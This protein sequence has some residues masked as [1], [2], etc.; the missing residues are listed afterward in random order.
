MCSHIISIT[1]TKTARTEFNLVTYNF[2]MLIHKN[3]YSML[4]LSTSIYG[5][6]FFFFFEIL[7]KKLDKSLEVRGVVSHQRQT[8][9]FLG[10]SVCRQLQIKEI[11]FQ[12][13]RIGK[14]D[15]S[16]TSADFTS[17]I[18]VLTTCDP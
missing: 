4:I 14:I 17:Q 13:S 5:D 11:R 10:S 6:S 7:G 3:L 1:I 2:R 16:F 15:F 18:I 12:I 9:V 8:F